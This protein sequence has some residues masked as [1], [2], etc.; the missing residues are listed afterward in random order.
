MGVSILTGESIAQ[1]S[2]AVL[3]DKTT[4]AKAKAAAAAAQQP[5]NVK[6]AVREIEKSGTKAAPTTTRPKA[7]QAQAET[8]KLQVHAEAAVRLMDDDDDDDDVEYC[9]PRPKDLPYESDV[10]PDGALTF[11]GLKRENM[12]RGYY[13]Y[14]VNPVDEHGV[15]AA[16]RRMQERSR[17]ALEECDRRVREDMENFEWAIQDELE[18]AGVAPSLKRKTAAPAPNPARSDR[19]KAPASAATRKAPSTVAS[20]NAA[21]ALAMDDGTRSLQRRMARPAE[22]S[23]R[24]LPPKKKET[25]GTT[26]A[27]GLGLAIPG[28]RAARQPTTRLPV[29]SRIPSAGAEKKGIEANSRTTIGYSKGRATAS[30]L[31]QQGAASKPNP[32]RSVGGGLPRPDTAVSATDSERTV[33]PSLFAESQSSA[34]A[35][36]EED[37]Q[38]KERVPFLSI[39]NPDLGVDDDD[40]DDCDLL[41]GGLPDSL[42]GDDDDDGFEL[43]LDD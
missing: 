23:G 8:H 4:N 42:C 10:F 37:Q 34:A 16:D 25:T 21:S 6:S 31:A 30:A 14:Y 32:T 36:A 41:A 28:F 11:E 22:S 13:D 12:F 15:S 1:R 38:W 18:E 27:T 40:D 5:S 35:A 24:S 26:T 20:R 33:T 2:R 9:P 19:P 17:Q 29:A 7:K 43:R 39:F 3:G